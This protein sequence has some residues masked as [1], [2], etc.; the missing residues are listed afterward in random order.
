[1]LETNAKKSDFQS[2]QLR[3]LFDQS[4]TAII[5]NVIMAG[6]VVASVWDEITSPTAYLWVSLI[7]AAAVMRALLSRAFRLSAQQGDDVLKWEQPYLFTLALT[8]LLWGL[9]LAYVA[10][11]TS[12]L[13]QL[14]LGIFAV[15]MCGAAFASYSANFWA[16]CIAMSCI[17]IPL[18]MVFLFIGEQAHYM[19]VV[20]SIVLVIAI[21]RNLHFSLGD[22]FKVYTL[23]IEIDNAR[24]KIREIEIQRIQA[25]LEQADEI[26]NA[27]DE[28]VALINHEIRTPLHAIT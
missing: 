3:L 11:Q 17:L 19:V 7:S 4:R 5:G 1:M 20:G 14:V 25:Q 15:G 28:F 18:D 6:L 10:T 8:S 23:N 9:G 2:R 27:K 22:S 16:V 21:L 12:D 24:Q 13:Y 26:L